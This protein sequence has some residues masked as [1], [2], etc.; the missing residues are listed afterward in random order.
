LIFRI[1]KG[2]LPQDKLYEACFAIDALGEKAVNEMRNWFC[3]FILEPYK[4][5]FAPGKYMYIIL[6][7]FDYRPE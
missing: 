1:E 4:R 3:S 7:T 6:I 2:G 5:L